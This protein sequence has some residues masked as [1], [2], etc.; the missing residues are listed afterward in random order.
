MK[1]LRPFPRTA[2]VFDKDGTLI[3]TETLYYEAF[4][5]LLGACGVR[6]DIPT[7]VRMMGTPLDSCVRLL[8]DRHPAISRTDAMHAHLR[9][10]FLRLIAE[11]RRERGTHAMRGA[12]AL[13][14]RCR[15][16]GI[17]LAMATSANREN[18]E[19]D[20]RTLGWHEWFE[21]VVT[22]DDVARH[23]PSPDIYLETARRLCLEPRECIAFED[24]VNGALSAHAAG[25]DV[26]F[27]R[28]ERFGIVAPP[29]T[30][31]VVSTL[32]ELL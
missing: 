28:D 25:M 21:A 30:S 6:H 8:Q 5:R 29:V 16:D 23:K 14:E 9:S 4:D 15:A 26:I 24:G 18:T 7:H 10:E 19:R 32:K 13:L 31:L 12:H 17:R 3:D 2:Y 20:L 22:G 11:V 27:V 1:L